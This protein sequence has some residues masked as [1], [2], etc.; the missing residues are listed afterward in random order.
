[1]VRNLLFPIISSKQ[2]SDR[3]ISTKI[4]TYN[5]EATLIPPYTEGVCFLNA[6]VYDAP[7]NT[8]QIL[9]ILGYHYGY[10]NCKIEKIYGSYD[11]ISEIIF[12]KSSGMLKFKFA[13]Q[14]MLCRIMF[15]KNK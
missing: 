9:Y 2:N 4:E 15:F 8:E 5:G 6:S 7:S 11:A 1:M 10:E 13:S 12:D 14:S 3:V